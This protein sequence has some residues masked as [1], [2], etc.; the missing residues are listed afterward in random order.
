MILYLCSRLVGDAVSP[1]WKYNAARRRTSY[2]K[3]KNNGF[4]I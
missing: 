1:S 3:P 4:V 2:C